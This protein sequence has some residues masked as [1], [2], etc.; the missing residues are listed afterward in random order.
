MR[1]LPIISNNEVNTYSEQIYHIL[2]KPVEKSKARKEFGHGKGGAG[3][4]ASLYWDEFTD[5]C[6]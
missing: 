2:M 1:F 5:K 3:V 6:F 4:S